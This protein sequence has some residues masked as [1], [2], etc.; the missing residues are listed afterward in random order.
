MSL[1]NTILRQIRAER[2]ARFKKL[3]LPDDFIAPNYRGRSIVNLTASVIKLFGGHIATTPLDADILADVGGDVQRVVLVIVDALGYHKFL[4][5]LDA[6]P[7]NG[8]HA[9]AQNGARIVPLTSTFPSTTTAALTS[10]WTGYTPAEH[11]FLGYQLFLR[12]YGARTDMIY[13]S[14]VAT[15]NL[16]REQL[17]DVGLKPENFL[18]TPSLPQTLARVNVPVYHFIE[19]PFVKSALSQVQIRGARELTG[20]ITTSD[21]WVALRDCV[22][23]HR[24]ERALFMAYWS[25]LDNIAHK[26]GPSS[27]TQIAEVANFAYSFEREF[28]ARL[29]RPARAQTLFL[30]T[31]D[32]GQVDSPIARA[33]NLYAHPDLRARLTMDFTGDARAAYLYCRNG[34]VNAVRD[35]FATRLAEKFCLLDSFAALDA[36]LFGDGILAPETEHRIGDLIALSRDDFYLWDRKEE[37]QLLGRHG[38]LAEDEMLVPLL[39]AR[40]DD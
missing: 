6:K 20:F 22:E 30:L 35:Y 34:Q 18:A 15:R 12:E 37:P 7:R 4:E 13:F 38:A 40:L 39:A 19:E 24:N 10:L 8:F 33:V 14:P 31:A 36:G 1:E 17:I 23:G 27:E 2:D 11:G 16:G 3:K 9:L 26:Y 25:G 21:L 5:S 29:S 32:H 28:L